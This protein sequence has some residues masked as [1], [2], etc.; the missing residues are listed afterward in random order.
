M[1][2]Q[3]PELPPEPQKEL[4]IESKAPREAMSEKARKAEEGLAILRDCL[5]E[6]ELGALEAIFERRVQEIFERTEDE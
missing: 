1:P 4:E 5:S 2:D 6:E 3:N